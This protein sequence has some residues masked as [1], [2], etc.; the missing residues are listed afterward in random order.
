MANLEV[1][2]VAV[3]RSKQVDDAKTME[4]V[5]MEKVSRIGGAVPP[6]EFVELIGKGAFGRVYKWYAAYV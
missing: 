3:T 6:Y 5:V 2:S 1:P 4:K